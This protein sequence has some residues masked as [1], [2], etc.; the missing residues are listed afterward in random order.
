MEDSDFFNNYFKDC[1]DKV[2][3]NIEKIIRYKIQVK[4]L[5]AW[6]SIPY[7]KKNSVHEKKLMKLWD[8]I[9]QGEKLK[10]RLTDQWIEIGF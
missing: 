1:K 4:R 9:K 8:N 3:R 7:D 2:Y 6:S 10:N 5:D